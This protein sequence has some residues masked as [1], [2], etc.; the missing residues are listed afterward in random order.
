MVTANDVLDSPKASASA[1]APLHHLSLAVL[2]QRLMER[3]WG[4]LRS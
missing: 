1:S 3:L 2:L 4:R